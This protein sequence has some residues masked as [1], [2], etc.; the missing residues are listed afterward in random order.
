MGNSI[1]IVGVSGDFTYSQRIDLDE[2]NVIVGVEQIDV[3]DETHFWPP[4][5]ATSPDYC[6]ST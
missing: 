4:L 5:I 6:V 1:F 3:L 2:H